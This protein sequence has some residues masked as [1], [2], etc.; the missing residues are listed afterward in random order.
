MFIHL[1]FIKSSVESNEL[2]NSIMRNLN[3]I[4]LIMN[5]VF[6]NCFYF[7]NVRYLKNLIAKMHMI[8]A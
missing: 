7:L 3:F 5:M 6:C 8:E 1:R 2:R 4:K